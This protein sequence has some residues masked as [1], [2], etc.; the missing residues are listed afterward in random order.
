MLS[1]FW[2]RLALFVH[3]ATSVGFIGAG[4]AFLVLAI[5]GFAIT[6]AA[7]LRGIYAGTDLL[8]VYLLVPL[9]WLSLLVGIVQSFGTPWGLF[10]Y[11]WIIVK[12]ALTSLAVVILMLEAQTIA[13]IGELGRAGD[14]AGEVTA[15]A[16]MIGH[17]AGGIL[18]LL[19]VMALSV[20]KPRGLTPYGARRLAA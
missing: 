15:R 6:D 2:R 11:Y 20:Y 16:G 5:A 7:M 4:G 14:V 18:L 19:V 12:L 17:A 3:V 10:R 13:R 1:P 9:A 8:T